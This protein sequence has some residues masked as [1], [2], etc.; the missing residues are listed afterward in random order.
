MT[1][2]SIGRLSKPHLG[3]CGYVYGGGLKLFRWVKERHAVQFFDGDTRRAQRR[4]TPLI[5]VDVSDLC[6]LLED[7]S[8]EGA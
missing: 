8:E 7:D 5:E 1:D 3:H 6:D 2:R 4:G